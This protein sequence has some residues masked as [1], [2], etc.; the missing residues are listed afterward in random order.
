[1]DARHIPRNDLQNLNPGTVEKSIAPA[2]IGIAA[3]TKAIVL[4][5]RSSAKLCLSVS[6]C[7]QGFDTA[8]QAVYPCDPPLLPFGWRRHTDSD[9]A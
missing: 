4:F 9:T 6:M 2:Y 5:A 7:R 8:H 3:S 1:M